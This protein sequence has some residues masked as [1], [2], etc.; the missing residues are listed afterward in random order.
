MSQEPQETTATTARSSGTGSPV[1]ETMQAWVYESAKGGMEHRMRLVS[2][3]PVPETFR[4][5][6]PGSD[7]IVVCVLAAAVNPVDYKIPE[8]PVVGRFLPRRPA[9]PASD[10]CGRVVAATAPG[11]VPGQLVAGKTNN[12]AQHGALAQYVLAQSSGCVVV[13]EGVDVDQAASIG[14]CGPTAWNA[15]VPQLKAVQAKSESLPAGAGAPIPCVF[16]NGGSGGVGCFAIQIAKAQGYHVT[17]TCSTRNVEFCRSLGADVVI[18]YSSTSVADTLAAQSA[19][20]QAQHPFDLA[21]DLVGAPFALYKAADS[22]LVQNGRYVQVAVSSITEA[23]WINVLPSFLGGGHHARPV[24]MND[25]DPA[26]E[27]LV[28][29]LIAQ[30]K[31]KVPIEEV[32]SFDDAPRAYTMLKTHRTRGKIIVRVAQD[33]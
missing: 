21:V 18:D 4:L 7:A 5:L 20:S 11:F 19:T 31:I 15:L 6:K 3:Y 23:L 30:R 8:L 25:N 1:P 22:C 27:R 14:I 28:L 26:A 13:P 32:V 9:T 29:D 2:D 16:I 10:F 12:M 33:D 17:T 24:L